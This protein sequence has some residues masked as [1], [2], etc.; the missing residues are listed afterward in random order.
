MDSVTFPEILEKKTHSEFVLFFWNSYFFFWRT[1]SSNN[2]QKYQTSKK[3][4]E[5]KKRSEK[6]WNAIFH[7]NFSIS[8]SQKQFL[9]AFFFLWKI[10]FLRSCLRVHPQEYSVYEGTK[11]KNTH[12]CVCV[13]H[14]GIPFKVF[15]C[16]RMN[17]ESICIL[18]IYIQMNYCV[19]FP[20]HALNEFTILKNEKIDKQCQCARREKSR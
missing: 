1:S 4:Q 11:L 16:Y 6:Q 15:V 17:S 10:S 2:A 8:T 18:L 12:V 7:K 14:L 3:I 9:W 19:P 13:L 20:L 5:S